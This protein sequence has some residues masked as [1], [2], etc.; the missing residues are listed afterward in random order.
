MRRLIYLLAAVAF[1]SCGH[2][3]KPVRTAETEALLSGLSNSLSQGIMYGHHDDS[4][5]GHGWKFEDGR[6]DVKSV[7]GDYPAVISFDLGEL[8]LGTGL[9]IDE[10]PFEKIRQEAVRQYERGGL[11]S[12]SWHPRNPRTGGDAWDLSDSSVVENVLPGGDC[13]EKFSGW[14]ASVAEFISSVKT[15]DGTRVPILF[16]PWHEHT[17]SW[18]W[19]GHDLCTTEQYKALWTMTVDSLAAHG[20][21]NLL[22]AYSPGTEPTTPEEYLERYPGDEIVSVLGFDCYQFGS[23]SE[24]YTANMERMISLVETV[25]GEHGKIPAVTETGYESIP[26]P[27]WWTGTLL[28][29]LKGHTLAYVLTWRNAHDKDTHFYGPFPG[30]PCEQDFVAFHDDP[31]TLFADDVNLY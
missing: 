21:D 16:R 25:A 6:S 3:S 27:E 8:E 22:Y 14:L 20:V 17:G 28:P 11:V 5:Y 2:V 1:V 26:D 12:F 30:H 7:C 10:V 19:W 9:S 31:L 15:A 23:G 18:F 4:V 29:V 13:H 24:A